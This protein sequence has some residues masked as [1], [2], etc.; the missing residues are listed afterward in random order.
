MMVFVMLLLLAKDRG[1]GGEF[2]EPFGVVAEAV[3]QT[4]RSLRAAVARLRDVC[5]AVAAQPWLVCDEDA[6]PGEPTLIIRSYGVWN[7]ENRGGARPGAGRPLKSKRNQTDSPPD[8]SPDPSPE[9]RSKNT[10]DP[11]Q[12]G[13]ES[14]EDLSRTEIASHAADASR[15]WAE[16]P[17]RRQ[18]SPVKFRQ[19]FAL[20]RR[21]FGVGVDLLVSKMGAYYASVDGRGE[22]SRTPARLM[23]D[24]FWEEPE[25]A[26]SGGSE[27]PE[28]RLTRLGALAKGKR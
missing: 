17:P 3:G 19:E 28:E 26:W 18:R 27:S 2:R 4:S 7:E 12:N 8:P 5:G 22:Y 15:V 25:E 20:A 24:A 16:V 23:A 11:E 13:A 10:V 6:A 9:E 21:N 1:N 14:I